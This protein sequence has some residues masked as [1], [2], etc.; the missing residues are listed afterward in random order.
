M[1]E[2]RSGAKM[3]VEKLKR[4]AATTESNAVIQ[5]KVIYFLKNYILI[6]IKLKKYIHMY[7][8]VHNCS[9][10]LFKMH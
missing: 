4:A 2:L 6:L 3:E 5:M 10:I 7:V 9:I 1:E 8:Y